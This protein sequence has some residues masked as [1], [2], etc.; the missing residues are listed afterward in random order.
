MVLGFG[1]EDLFES[2]FFLA[3]IS[4]FFCVLNSRFGIP[5]QEYFNIAAVRRQVT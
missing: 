1:A 3:S 5:K 4:R 2:C